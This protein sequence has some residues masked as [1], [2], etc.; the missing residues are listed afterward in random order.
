[1]ASQ[2]LRSA[3]V[4]LASLAVPALAHAREVADNFDQLRFVL[5]PGSDLRIVEADGSTVK[6]K[7]VGFSGQA[8]D[9]V[10]DGS[11]HLIAQEDVVRIQ[12][13]K[14]DSLS[15]GARNGFFAGEPDSACSAEL[16][17]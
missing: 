12:Q 9:L 1:M 8:L 3:L 5:P 13:R 17:S 6:G 14:D 16:Q 4:L 7:F 15:N 10:V 11:R 2:R